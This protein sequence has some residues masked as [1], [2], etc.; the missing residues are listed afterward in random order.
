MFVNR[1]VDG[2]LPLTDDSRN[3]VDKT[4]LRNCLFIQFFW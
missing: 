3:V 2:M 1:A 4:N